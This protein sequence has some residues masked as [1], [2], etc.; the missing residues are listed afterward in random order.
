MFAHVDNLVSNARFCAQFSHTEDKD[1]LLCQSS[2]L[3]IEE[4]VMSTC[5]LSCSNFEGVTSFVFVVVLNFCRQRKSCLYCQSCLYCPLSLL[6]STDEYD[7]VSAVRCRAQF[8]QIKTEWGIICP[9]LRPVFADEEMSYVSPVGCRALSVCRQ[10]K[11]IAS[12]SEVVLSFCCPLPCSVLS[13]KNESVLSCPLSCPV[14]ANDEKSH[15]SPVRC[16]V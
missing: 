10:R 6:I 9:L 14:F 4:R 3:V 15:G 8:W 13:N 1:M 7:N 11:V 16:P 5:Q 2:S 12:Q